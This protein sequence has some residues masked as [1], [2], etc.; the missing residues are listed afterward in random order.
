MAGNPSTF[1]HAILRDAEAL[2]AAVEIGV[3]LSGAVLDTYRRN[4]ESNLD[5]IE[6]AQEGEMADRRQLT[7]KGGA[8]KVYSGR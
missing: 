7:M 6:R 8:H 4:F 5:L 3:R 2:V 1:A